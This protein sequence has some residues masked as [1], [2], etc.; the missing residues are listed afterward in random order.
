MKKSI[1]ITLFTTSK[2]KKGRNEN[3]K[4]QV[5]ERREKRNGCC[6]S[7]YI[8]VTLEIALGGKK[9]CSEENSGEMYK[10]VTGASD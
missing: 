6:L 4:S 5:E 10:I 7:F 2:E 3:W 1:K 9:I 8:G